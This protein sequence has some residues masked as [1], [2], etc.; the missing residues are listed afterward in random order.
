MAHSLE[1]RVPFLDK[2]MLNIALRIPSEYRVTKEQTKVALRK[3]AIRELPE[4]TANRRK[5]GF[6]SPLA[7]WLKEDAYFQMVKD[8]FLTEAANHF[9]E[10][11]ELLALLEE[12]RQEGHSNMQ[13]IW[14]VYSFL[15]WYEIYFGTNPSW[16]RPVEKEPELASV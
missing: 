1:L 10:Q 3:A 12:H 13:K 11:N 9:F 2:E 15:V 16:N 7:Q 6:P 4:Q 5:L 8:Q 14:S